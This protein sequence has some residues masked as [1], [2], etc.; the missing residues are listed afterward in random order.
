MREVERAKRTI[1]ADTRPGD[2]EVNTGLEDG[3][4]TGITVDTDPGGR[5]VRARA[6]GWLLGGGDR[7]GTRDGLVGSLGD[8]DAVSLA[9]LS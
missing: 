6:A 1:V 9:V 7:E 2:G 5:G 8:G 3:V 4:A